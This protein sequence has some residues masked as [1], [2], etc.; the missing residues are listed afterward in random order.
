MSHNSSKIDSNDDFCP[1]WEE[2]TRD[3][4]A[5]PALGHECCLTSGTPACSKRNES[6]PDKSEPAVVVKATDPF[7]VVEELSFRFRMSS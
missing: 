4:G 2:V 5:G 1:F 7:A 3:T 6:R